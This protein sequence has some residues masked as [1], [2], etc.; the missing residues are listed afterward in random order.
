MNHKKI[1]L[2]RVGTE[3]QK[4][5]KEIAGKKDIQVFLVPLKYYEEEIGALAGVMGMKIHGKQYAGPEFPAE[6][7]I[8]SGLDSDQLDEFLKSY[9]DARIEPI[10]LKAVL[11]PS[12]VQWTPLQL[13]QELRKEHM[14]F[15]RMK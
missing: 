11:T 14:E 5:I 4:K 2:F 1:L 8:F 6:M 7:M 3:K 15:Q 13:Q 10:G 9:R 12:N